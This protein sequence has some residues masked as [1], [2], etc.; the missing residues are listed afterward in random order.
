MKIAILS[1]GPQLYSTKS[2]LT[3]G[4]RKGHQM[5]I[6]DHTMCD[7]RM[8]KEA[9]EV[10]HKGEHLH[11]VEALIPRIGSSVTFQGAAVIQHF[12]LMKVFTTARSNALLQC[13]DKLRC[14]QKLSSYGIDVPKTVYI[15]FGQDVKKAIEYVGG[16]PVIIKVNESTH[17]NGV[18]L[19]ETMRTATN[20]IETFQCLKERIMI[21][22]FIKE[23]K[24]EDI[25]ALVVAGKVVAAMK[26]SAKA[27][28]FRSNLHQG[29]SAE[30]VRLNAR[31]KE[32]AVRATQIMGLD[33]AGVDLLRSKRGPL[34][35]EINA[36][37]GLEGIETITG[38]DVAGSVIAFIERK[39]QHKLSYPLN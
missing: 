21:Q 4:I 38:I 15:G 34:I 23:S 3:A 27:G 29:A 1:R 37:P 17:G 9:M 28:D 11:D 30:A 32:L 8:E 36:S 25:R 13:R 33:V 10:Y 22:E 2:L 26:R 39:L 35:L 31:E 6:I 14:T 16:L 18:I 24:G 12:E 5:R 19:A 20:I 7:L